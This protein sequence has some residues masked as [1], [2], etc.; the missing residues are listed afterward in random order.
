MRSGSRFLLSHRLFVQKISVRAGTGLL[1]L[2]LL[3]ACAKPLVLN[4]TLPQQLA[5]LRCINECRATK[6]GC[7]ADARYDYRQCQAGYGSSFR[8][9]RWCLASSSDRTQCGYPWWSC[10]ENLYGYCANRYSECA[11]ACQGVGG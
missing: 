9:Y 11:R 7:V 4:A 6:E 1:S 2:L 8:V 3:A 5:E 10:A